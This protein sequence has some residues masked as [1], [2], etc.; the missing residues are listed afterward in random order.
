MLISSFKKFYV[1]ISC[2]H[3]FISRQE[4]LFHWLLPHLQ[5]RC[6]FDVSS[7]QRFVFR[8]WKH[9]ATDLIPFLKAFTMVFSGLHTRL[10]SKVNWPECCPGW[11]GNDI[12]PYSLWKYWVRSGHPFTR[13]YYS[14]QSGVISAYVS[15]PYVCF[16]PIQVPVCTPCTY[17]D[18]SYWQRSIGWTRNVLHSSPPD[19]CMM[20]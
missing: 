11:T 12:S 15:I 6:T 16:I 19:E 9:G 4:R 20:V 3:S 17:R 13:M 14:L 5:V 18:L 7:P 10:L 8:R 1:A 2:E